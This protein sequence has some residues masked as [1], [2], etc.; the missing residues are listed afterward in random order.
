MAVLHL[1]EQGSTLRLRAGRLWIELDGQHLRDMPARKVHLVSVYGNVRLTTPALSFFLRS[2][3]PIMFCSLDGNLHGVAHPQQ[4]S[5]ASQLKA[6]FAASASELGYELARAFTLSKLSSSYQLICQY[7]RHYPAV[8]EALAQLQALLDK[9]E[10][11]SSLEQL[12]GYEGS[13]ARSYFQAL[14]QP[15]AR[16]GFTGRNRRPPRDPVNAALSYGYALLLGR[17]QL[18][19]LQAGLHPEVGMLHSESRRNPALCL[20]LMEEFR[21]PVVDVAVLRAF[22]RSKLQ[23]L[24]HFEDKHQGIYLNEPGRKIM[25]QVFEERLL[26]ET[27]HPAGWRRPYAETINQQAQL[28]AAAIMKRRSYTPY[29]L[30]AP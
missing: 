12:R 30:L 29:Y 13:G 9:L 15:L 18:A 22:N 17:I 24:A 7:Q 19:V 10:Q 20:D 5:P 1:I 28:L 3:T 14:Q 25:L 21:I 6:Q 11:S 4:L 26:Q 16:Y 27:P 2:Q 8:G 23:P